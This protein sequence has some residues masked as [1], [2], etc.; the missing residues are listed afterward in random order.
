MPID[1]GGSVGTIKVGTLACWEHLQPLLKYHTYSQGETVHV[2]MWPPINSFGTQPAPESPE[3]F[4]MTHDGAYAL[5]TTHAME[6]G[7]FV[8]YTTSVLS[9]QGI[10]KLG[11]KDG[12]ALRAPGGGHAAVIGPDGRTL[13]TELEGGPLKEGILFANLE[14]DRGVALKGFLDVVGHYSR[15][16]L[17]WL[18]VDKQDKTCVVEREAVRRA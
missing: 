3:L 16:D 7:T 11:S 5:S 8:L 17:L 18:G 2:A 12:V 6:G 1:F 14:L 10:E 4:S 13:T 15:P 9:E